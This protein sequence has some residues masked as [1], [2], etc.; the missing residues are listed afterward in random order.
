M[1]RMPLLLLALCVPV[2]GCAPSREDS[3]NPAPPS[4][5]ASTAAPTSATSSASRTATGRWD[6]VPA[7]LVALAGHPGDQTAAA[8]GFADTVGLGLGP[9]LITNAPRADLAGPPAWRLDPPE[10]HFRASVGPFSALDTLARHLDGSGRE[11]QRAFTV[12]EGDHPD[13]FGHSA[14]APPSLAGAERIAIQPAE[15]TTD[16]CIQWFSVDAFVRDERVVA[17]TLDLG[18]P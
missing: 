7:A 11:A 8:V 2:A 15:G 1:F 5:A 18:E 16:S 13:C 4:T 17:V 10:G 9:T 6:G 14:P 12:V 3:A